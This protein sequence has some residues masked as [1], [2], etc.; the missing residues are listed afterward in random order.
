MVGQTSGR[1]RLRFAPAALG[2]AALLLL[3]ATFVPGTVGEWIYVL[4][5]PLFPVL[6]ISL[7]LEGCRCSSLLLKGIVL[8]LGILLV[9]SAVG[10][11]LLDA[12]PGSRWL[13]GLPVSA[14]VMG[15]GLVL[16]PLLL[17]GFGFA[18]TFEPNPPVE[19]RGAG[20]SVREP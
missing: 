12:E 4:L 11:R 18:A 10:I 17:V 14:I 7:A 5:T 1:Q 15:L 19:E 16:A 13:M 9:V 3:A 20:A 6:L 8:T 2:A